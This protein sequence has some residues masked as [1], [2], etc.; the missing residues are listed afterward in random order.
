MNKIVQGL[1]AAIH[2]RMLPGDLRQ[3]LQDLRDKLP[4]G[5]RNQLNYAG[6]AELHESLRP[7]FGEQSVAFYAEMAEQALL[8]AVAGYKARFVEHMADVL[9]TE[10]MN[11]PDPQAARIKLRVFVRTLHFAKT[12]YQFRPIEARHQARR[13]LEIRVAEA[14]PKAERT[15]HERRKRKPRIGEII[16]TVADQLGVSEKTVRRYMPASSDE[17]M[18]K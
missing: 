13:S 2:S 16:A 18:D 12:E 5:P 14:W 17:I 10:I 3:E 4:V 9:R 6:L 15:V 8:P 11:L 1:D 7:L